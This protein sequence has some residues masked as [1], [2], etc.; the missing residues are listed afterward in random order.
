MTLRLAAAAI[1]WLGLWLPS[2]RSMLESDMALHMT[3]EL[4]LLAAVG[5]LIA[6]QFRRFEPRWLQEADWLGIPSIVLVLFS[7]S[8]W[9]LPLALDSALDDSRMEL[10]KFVSL[11]L[12]VG[13]PLALG[14]RRMPSL[15]RL[16]VIANLVSKIGA[17]GGLYLAAPIRLCAYY[18]LDQQVEAG[19]VLVTIAGGAIIA[20]FLAT[21][22]GW[23]TPRSIAGFGGHREGENGIMFAHE[24][25]EIEGRPGVLRLFPT[26]IEREL[27]LR[28]VRVFGLAA[29]PRPVPCRSDQRC[30]MRGREGSWIG[31]D[32]QF[33]TLLARNAHI[34]PFEYP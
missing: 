27:R 6:P 9:M 2:L 19:W 4:P 34:E 24:F 26:D 21:F 31:F 12:L 20:A 11:P 7:T 18:R 15:G 25:R 1:L 3:V 8:C 17:L 14:W 32:H 30:Q 29:K 5:I 10:L 22:I 33:G 28:R 13:L 23:P 16:F